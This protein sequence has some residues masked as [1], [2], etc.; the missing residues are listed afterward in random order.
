MFWKKVDSITNI[1]DS[2]EFSAYISKQKKK[3]GGDSFSQSRALGL[4]K[5]EGYFLKFQAG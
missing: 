3:W 4:I 1:W 5:D 2:L